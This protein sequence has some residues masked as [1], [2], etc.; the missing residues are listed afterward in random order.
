MQAYVK[1]IIYGGNDGIVSIF[2]GSALLP[3]RMRCC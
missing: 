3:T 1:D 2:G